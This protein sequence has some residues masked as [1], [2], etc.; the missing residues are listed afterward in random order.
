MNKYIKRLAEEWNHHG[1]IIISVDF[2]STL[3]YWPTIENKEDIDRVVKV[4]KE[5][6]LTGAYTVIFT[7][8]DE[9][10]FPQIE[11]HCQR[12]GINI[13]SI[14]KNPI[15]LPYGNSGKIFYNINLC[16]RSG[17][18]EAL[19]TL[20]KATYMQRSHLSSSRLNYPGSLGF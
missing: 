20:E 2:D 18:N 13:D 11:D 10:R 3:C 9:S 1:K 7:A 15:D 14:N 16:D 4:L 12:L 6:Q 8:S 17:L 19:D 5:A